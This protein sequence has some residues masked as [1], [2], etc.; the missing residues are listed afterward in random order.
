MNVSKIVLG[1]K[2]LEDIAPQQRF[3]DT[4]LFIKRSS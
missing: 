3:G 4:T 1:R 2:I